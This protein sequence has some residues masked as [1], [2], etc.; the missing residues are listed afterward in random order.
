MTQN[1]LQ[2]DGHRRQE[3]SVPGSVPHVASARLAALGITLPEPVSPSKLFSPAQL[4]DGIVRTSGQVPVRNG[5][6]IALGAV[7]TVVSFEIAQEC[8]RQ[9]VLN[10]L[11]AI[12]AE[13]GDL[14]RIK[15]FIKLTVFVA[16]GEGFFGQPAVADAA[17]A[18][19]IDVLGP[20]A[21]MHTRTAVGVVSLPRNVPVEV[22][23]AAS[24]TPVR[25]TS[26]SNPTQ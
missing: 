22:E 15:G 16:S 23:V 26:E 24:V 10:A 1:T 21:G 5:V 17:S 3:V 13:I 7:G 11:A 6:P 14:D 12:Y 18:F 25:A 19:L 20:A 2:V 4:H 8:A 9:C